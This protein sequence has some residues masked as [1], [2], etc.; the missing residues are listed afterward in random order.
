MNATPETNKQKTD[1][2][3]FYSCSTVPASLAQK[4]ESEN[5]SLREAVQEMLEAWEDQFGEGACD[6]MDEPQNAG[7]VCQCC[8]ARL[9]LGLI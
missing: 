6:C 5:I 8:K 2:V 4:L 7:H 1:I 3:G 9:A